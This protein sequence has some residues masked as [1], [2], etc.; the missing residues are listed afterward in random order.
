MVRP[1]TVALPCLP[2]SLAMSTPGH[3]R[4]SAI[5]LP[6]AL[7]N[8]MRAWPLASSKELG[9]NRLNRRVFP[10]SSSCTG[11]AVFFSDSIYLIAP[12][13]CVGAFLVPSSVHTSGKQATHAT[14]FTGLSRLRSRIKL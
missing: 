9:T 12:I 11:L 7:F 13:P 2:K 4:S 10:A 14:A 8:F 1:F 5:Y 3:K 6:Q